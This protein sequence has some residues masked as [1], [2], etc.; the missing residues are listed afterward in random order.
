M[1]ILIFIVKRIL[2]AVPV[3][4]G[5]SILVFSLI[6]LVPG[7]PALVMLGLLQPPKMSPPFTNSSISTIP[8]GSST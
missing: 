2:I 3:L 7:D 4:I 5:M 6:H 1:G 8:S